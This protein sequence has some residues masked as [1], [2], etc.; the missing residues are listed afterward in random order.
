[1]IEKNGKWKK[2]IKGIALISARGLYGLTGILPVS[3]I[4]RMQ[5]MCEDW[6]SVSDAANI[7]GCPRETIIVEASKGGIQRDSMIPNNFGKEKR[8][9]E[10]IEDL[11]SMR[12]LWMPPPVAVEYI[13]TK[14]SP[15]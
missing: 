2:K 7:R 14:L 4:F 10:E 5:L 9:T 3:F 15:S 13:I 6:V 8:G 12:S 1:M 11:G